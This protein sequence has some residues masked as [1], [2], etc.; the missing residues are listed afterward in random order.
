MLPCSGVQPL[1]GQDEGSDYDAEEKFVAAPEHVD[2][3]RHLLVRR[4]SQS[5]LTQILTLRR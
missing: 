4:R 1:K 3:M 2:G 5:I